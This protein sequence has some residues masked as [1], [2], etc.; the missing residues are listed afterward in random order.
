[1]LTEVKTERGDEAKERRRKQEGILGKRRARQNFLEK[2]LWIEK[3]SL[4][5]QCLNKW[6]L[7]SEK[8]WEPQK[9]RGYL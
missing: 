3:L 4:C 5:L 7:S 8:S 9:K 6:R 2:I 1:V